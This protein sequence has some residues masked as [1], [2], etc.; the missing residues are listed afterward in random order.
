MPTLMSRPTAIGPQSRAFWHPKIESRSI[1]KIRPAKRNARTHSKKQTEKLIGI[2]RRFGFINPIIIDQNGTIVAGHLRREVAQ[3]LGMTHVPVICITHLSELEKKAFALAEN[4][5][6]L[7][8]G[9]D[10]EILAADL[11][12]LAILLPEADIELAVT[13]FDIAE[14]DL[15]IADHAE[16]TAANVAA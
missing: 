11:G 7:D 4:R 1:K 13:A 3:Q 12:E 5:I 16:A 9:W 2:I 14:M 6:S 15:I 8:S 10:R